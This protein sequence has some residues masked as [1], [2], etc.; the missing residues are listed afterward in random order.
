[1]SIFKDEKEMEACL[2]KM[3]TPQRE[4]FRLLISQLIECYVDDKKHGVVI[5]GDESPVVAVMA[6]NATDMDAVELLQVADKHLHYRAVE[7]APPKE[8]FN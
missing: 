4:H 2:D 1:M 7:D 5:I 3:S 6:V 8:M